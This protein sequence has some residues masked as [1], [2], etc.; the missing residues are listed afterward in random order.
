MIA[1][2]S[3]FID[4]PRSEIQRGLGG[5]TTVLKGRVVGPAFIVLRV[6]LSAIKANI[7]TG[8]NHAIYKLYLAF[9]LQN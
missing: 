9:S 1:D 6:M 4:V 8:N 3:R 7:S 2:D 5:G